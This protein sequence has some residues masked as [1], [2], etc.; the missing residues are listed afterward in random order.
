MAALQKSKQMYLSYE[1]SCTKAGLWHQRENLQFLIQEA[2]A[3]GRIPVIPQVILSQHHNF[4]FEHKSN[5]SK[6]FDWSK[7]KIK[8]HDSNIHEPVQITLDSDNILKTTADAVCRVPANVS[9]SAPK[10]QNV[11]FVIKVVN[12]K[13]S[14]SNHGRWLCMSAGPKPAGFHINPAEFSSEVCRIASKIIR[15]M[16][17]EGGYAAI[18]I[19]RG[20]KLGSTGNETTPEKVV[21]YLK[22]VVGD[23]MPVYLLTDDFSKS[24]VAEINSQ[25]PVFC[26]SRFR[27]LRAIICQ[28]GLT[29]CLRET[30]GRKPDNFML[31]AIEMSILADATIPIFTFKT[32]FS[33]YHLCESQGWV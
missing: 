29:R 28:T 21:T 32:K 20:D 6:Y 17:G 4:G 9:L 16:K 23:G 2:Y 26:Y 3:H 12:A 11:N 31:Y 8:H 5:L 30:R 13:L 33:P 19:R 15:K 24:Y 7:S 18:H 1:D 10:F 22:G 14:S 25:F 27:E